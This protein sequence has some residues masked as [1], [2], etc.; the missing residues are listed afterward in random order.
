MLFPEFCFGKNIELHRINNV[1]NCGYCFFSYA[2]K[3]GKFPVSILL[4]KVV[5]SLCRYERGMSARYLSPEF[6]D[7]VGLD[8]EQVLT[9]KKG[10][11]TL[12]KRRK[13]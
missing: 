8:K 9:L 12:R 5:C 7:E 13:S 6:L 3:F 2:N 1:Q 4:Q 11:Y 10:E